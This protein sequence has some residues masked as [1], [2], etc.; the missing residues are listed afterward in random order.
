MEEWLRTCRTPKHL[1]KLYQSTLKKIDNDVEE[2][3]ISEDSVEP[4]NLDVSNFFTISEGY[5][6]HLVD[7]EYEIV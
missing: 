2:N 3:L 7:D 1:V 4:M 5:V 6:N